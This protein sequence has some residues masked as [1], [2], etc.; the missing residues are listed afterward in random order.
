M[1]SRSAGRGGA[2]APPCLK[3]RRPAESLLHPRPRPPCSG[4]TP[5]PREAPVSRIRPILAVFAAALTLLT[6]PPAPRARAAIPGGDDPKAYTQHDLLK[7]RLD[8]NRRTLT[9]AYNAVGDR[10]PKW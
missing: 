8:F 3:R 10:N 6:C 7:A 5:T 1:G 2:P 9:G 4:D